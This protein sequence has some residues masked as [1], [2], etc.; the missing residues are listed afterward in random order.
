MAFSFT[1]QSANG[2]TVFGGTAQHK[3]PDAESFA[4]YM[5]T[6]A[7]LTFRMCRTPAVEAWS[8]ADVPATDYVN[9]FTPG[10]NASLAITVGKVYGISEDNVRTLAVIRD[11]N[12][13]VVD[14]LTF[15]R[16]WSSMWY[17]NFGKLDLFALPQN[18]GNYTV[19]VYFNEALV[20]TQ[21]FSIA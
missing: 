12:G 19:E 3:L 17:K 9:T 11:E 18:I 5:L 1:I 20:T 4:G 6:A 8:A 21:N 2:G 14:T 7:D 10:E 13:N 15:T 16:T